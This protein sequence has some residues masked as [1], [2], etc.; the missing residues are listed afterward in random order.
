MYLMPIIVGATSIVVA[1]LVNDL[2][3]GSNRTPETTFI[4]GVIVI[5]VPALLYLLLGKKI[6]ETT[7]HPPQT[8][9]IWGERTI[10]KTTR[11]P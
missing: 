9:M 2:F 10:K 3:W 1:L 7:C 5:I 11:H 4:G 6:G 8:Q